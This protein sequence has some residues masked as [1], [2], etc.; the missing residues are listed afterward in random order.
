MCQ[1]EN[2]PPDEYKKQWKYQ[3]FAFPMDIKYTTSRPAVVI[4]L[5]SAKHK[6]YKQVQLLQT[7]RAK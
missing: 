1:G 4:P 2:N 5:K 7:L 6:Y 3:L